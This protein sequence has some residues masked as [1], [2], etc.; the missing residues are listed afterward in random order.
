ME[1][2]PAAGGAVEV[3]AVPRRSHDG[4][5]ADRDQTQM[6]CRYHDRDQTQMNRRYHDG[7]AAERSPAAGGAVEQFP[8]AG[9]A[10]EVGAVPRRSH[11]GAVADGDQT[12]M[13]CRYHDR[14]QT[15]MNRR[16]HDGRAAERSPA[17]GGA[18][19]QF[20]AA[21]GAVE[22]GAVPRRSHDGA[23]ADRVKTL[24]V[25]AWDFTAEFDSSKRVWT[26]A[27]K[28][29]DGIG[30]SSLANQVPEYKVAA[31]AREQYDE[32]LELWLQRGWLQPYDEQADGPPRGLIPLM[33]VPQ[34]TKVRPVLDMR[35]LN[36]HV[37]AYTADADVCAEHLRKWR[38]HGR[39]V[40]VVHL[41]RAYLQLRLDR[42]LWP[43]Q[44]VIIRGR[45]FCLTRLG[46][47]L[48]VAP[49]VM[50]AVV[51]AVLEQDPEI[52]RSVSPY[53]DDLLVDEDQVSADRVAAHFSRFGLECKPPARAED[54]ARLLG[55]RVQRASSGELQW[56]RDN[57]VPA[58]PER[59]TR[60]AVF[61]W[62]GRL[63]AHLP[64]CGWLR[65]AAAWLKRRVNTVTSGW[66]DATDDPARPGTRPVVLDR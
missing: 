10:V 45:R 31:S 49:S 9:G 2:F 28:W 14:D 1:Q 16:Y 23:V 58:P 13:H 18:V 38:R 46:F 35:E 56:S 42:R 4:A 12:Q 26:V 55:L 62:C 33:A 44:T 20:P 17:A 64:V 19:E 22:V 32:E 59:V 48:N 61:A 29:T 52:E 54:G 63:V 40:A 60:R 25:D 7:R 50:K 8:A 47:G 41:R 15:Q 36:S 57:A 21:G 3:G 34:A 39:L 43:Y 6:H 53:M 5:V 66:D 30:P 27:W 11:D 24:A 65:P 51:R 37:A